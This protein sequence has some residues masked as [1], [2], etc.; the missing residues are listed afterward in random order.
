MKENFKKF[1]PILLQKEGYYSNH[2]WDSGKETL[3]GIS[4]RFNPDWKGWKIWDNISVGEIP[5]KNKAW[6]LLSDHVEKLYKSRYWDQINADNL[7]SGVD[8][9]C[10]DMAVNM[11]VEKSSKILQKVVEAFPDG[12]VGKKTLNKVNRANNLIGKLCDQRAVFYAMD[13]DPV[14]R[15]K[16]IKGWMRRNR[17]VY[18]YSKTLVK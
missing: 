5:S 17:E 16:A 7:P 2:R 1:L 8:T 4:R 12:I 18:E 11:G 15:K 14:A 13:S 3:F 10:F 9:F 6:L